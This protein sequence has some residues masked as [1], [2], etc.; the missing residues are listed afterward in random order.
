[1]AEAAREEPSPSVHLVGM[2]SLKNSTTS[3][4][5]LHLPD[6]VVLS[7]SNDRECPGFDR[8]PSSGP[9]V[10]SH[11]PGDGRGFTLP[12]PTSHLPGV[13]APPSSRDLRP[14]RKRPPRGWP[15]K[16]ERKFRGRVLDTQ[17]V[18]GRAVSPRCTQTVRCSPRTS[19]RDHI[20][21]WSL[22]E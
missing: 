10:G 7:L 1:M 9:W 4:P 16:A 12:A 11:Q 3:C 22:K 13:P 14:H 5:G 19:E 8:E 6:P 17:T 15:L 18:L 2:N 20:W 21:R